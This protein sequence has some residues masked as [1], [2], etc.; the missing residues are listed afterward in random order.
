MTAYRNTSQNRRAMRVFLAALLGACSFAV[1]GDPGSDPGDDGVDAAVNTPRDSDGD[2]VLDAQDVCP[3]VNDPE[4]HDHDA[5]HRGDACDVCP[6][7]I[8]AG[9]DGDGDG[10]GDA[11]DPRPTLPGDRLA[12]FEGFYKPV[13]WDVVIGGDSWTYANGV[14][15]QANTSAAFQLIRDDNPDLG[16]VTVEARVQIQQITGDLTSRR[17]AGIVTGYRDA[18]TYWFCGLAAAGNQAEVDAGKVSWG[19]FGNSFNYNIGAFAAPV[20][21]DWAEM[22]ART[23]TSSSGDA[24]IEC[25]VK[26]NGIAGS[27]SYST[28]AE[29]S[30]DV[31]VR[32]NGAAASF[33]Y[34]F[35]V[36]S[37]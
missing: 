22:R 21:G 5:D 36:V 34:V 24:T 35:V 15:T 3:N 2:G 31:G 12:Y 28:N 29:G 6:H 17:S 8:D 11:C 33:D 27:A 14:T 23:G 10:V 37:P 16:H 19:L 9:A 25:S 30:G 20:P 32:T 13:A 1:P 4:Q 18:D 26:R 7:R